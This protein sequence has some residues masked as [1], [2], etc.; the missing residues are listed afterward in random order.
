MPDSRPHY[1]A[2]LSYSH[3][4][5]RWANRLH[6]ALEHFATPRPLIGAAT[7]VGPAPRRLHPVFRDREELGASADL[8]GRLV[9]ALEASGYLIVICSPAAA[10]SRWVNEEI[11][12][13]RAMHGHERILTVIVAGKPLASLDP[14]DA[15]QECFPE[16]LRRRA[17]DDVGPEPIAADLRPGR[18]GFRLAVLKLA[19]G[20]LGVGLDAL[21]QRDAR[22]RQRQ[23]T[24]LTAAS[25]A[26]SAV[27]AALTFAAVR[28]RNEAYAQRAQAE[29][30]IE[31]MIGDLRKKL[32]PI[33]G[34]DALDALGDRALAYY[35]A[36]QSHGMD[37]ASLGR[38]A[39]V[40]HLLGEIRDRRGDLAG[41]LA[42]FQE[43]AR[44]TGE[45][46]AR[47]PDDPQRIYDHAQSVYWV[48][49]VAW[50]RGHDNQARRAFLDYQHLADRLVAI[51]PKNA[52]WRGEVVY[53]NSDLGTVF[54]ADGEADAA[55]TAYQRAVED[56]ERLVQAAPSDR[57]PQFDLAQNLGSLER[58]E[59]LRDRLDLAMSDLAA[60]SALD[61]CMLARN[62]ADNGAKVDLAIS[63]SARA[64]ILLAQGRTREASDE[65]A[66]AQASLEQIIAAA[67]GDDS[68]K[69]A[70]TPILLLRAQVLLRTGALDAA[71]RAAT[72]AR[73]MAEAAVRKDPTNVAWSGDRLGEARVVSMKIAAAR[74]T[75]P[76]QQAAA[77]RGAPKEADRL[78]AL[79]R[80]QPRSLALARVVAQ[81]ELLAGDEASL[82]GEAARAQTY[83]SAGL[84]T[85]TAV[86]TPGQPPGDSSGALLRQ[87][88]D[89]LRFRRPPVMGASMVRPRGQVGGPGRTDYRW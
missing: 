46:L 28:E 11:A 44:S 26:A 74:A 42:L 21:V 10:R 50:R 63:R 69:F 5:A 4:D 16:A 66:A 20:M 43:A 81:A 8:G 25:L 65:L 40:L 15:D 52:A 86:G 77:L 47:A 36:Q 22:R 51:D 76:G 33:G 75:S 49:Y 78:A 62:P 59:Y 58:A 14:G 61:Q 88:D 45:L 32:E 83:W 18:D 79:A 2:F 57:G 80:A 48:G 87:L 38:R 55:A 24:I 1:W 19:A 71:A 6:R 23:L 72:A 34:L 67:P 17:G 68:Y 37:A 73:D 41:A 89:R 30:L 35:A 53:A 9:A 29:G 85:L 12:R 3:A 27:L 70:A 56:G 31:F 82:I 84:S 60:E 54:L 7:P 64:R 13:F 39:R